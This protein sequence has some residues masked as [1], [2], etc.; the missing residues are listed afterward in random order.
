MSTIRQARRASYRVG[1]FLGDVEAAQRSFK[2][3]SPS[4]LI[5]RALRKS[6]YKYTSHTLNRTLR[7]L[8]L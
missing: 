4:P 6:A 2:T 5:K 7:S 1:S 8:G 3:G